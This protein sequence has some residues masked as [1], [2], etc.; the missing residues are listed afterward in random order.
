[1]PNSSENKKTAPTAKTTKTTTISITTKQ[2]NEHD[3]RRSPLTTICCGVCVGD[4]GL[5]SLCSAPPTFAPHFGQNKSFDSMLEP[6]FTQNM[7]SSPFL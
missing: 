4:C 7:F 2:P 1:M 5:M 3:E 6:H